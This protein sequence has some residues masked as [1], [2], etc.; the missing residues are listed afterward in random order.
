MLLHLNTFVCS[1]GWGK[2]SESASRSG[3]FSEYEAGAVAAVA[4]NC[5]ATHLS[6]ERLYDVPFESAGGPDARGEAVSV[7]WIPRGEGATMSHPTRRVAPVNGFSPFASPFTLRFS[8][9][10]D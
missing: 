5:G 9:D 8:G 3:K 4:R 7:P 10:Y 1:Q 6:A 2:R